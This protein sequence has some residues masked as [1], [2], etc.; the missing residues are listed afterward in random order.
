MGKI[1]RPR[2]GSLQIWPRKRAAKAL[3]RVN[4][5]AIKHAGMT[6][7]IA[8]KAGMATAIVRDKTDKSMT[9]NKKIALPVTILEVPNLKIYSVR[10]YK[11]GKVMKEFVVS[12][13]KEL[14]KVVKVAKQPVH[15]LPNVEG[16]D[17][18]RVIVY[19]ITKDLY[20][21]TPNLSEVALK[22]PNAI[23]FVKTHIGKEIN[24]SEILT[25][26]IV[27]VRGLTKGKGLS[28]PVKRFG[29]SL[30]SHKAEKG[31]RRPGSLAPWH[32]ARVTFRTAM[33]G[34]LGMF[35]RVHYNL[36]VVFKG[37]VGE[38]LPTTYGFKHYGTI[39]GNY[40]ILAGSVQGAAKR[41]ILITAPLRPTKKQLK[42]KYEFLELKL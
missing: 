28:G 24:A 35:S 20:K 11:H 29:I 16:F 40:I 3:P 14:K 17:E 38:H 36:P 1:S 21:K 32:P 13:D 26:S 41:E 27:D 2:F 39:G 37:K 30:K 31:Q 23:D 12:H 18:I 5:S 25:W 10:F 9:A 7:V 33:A 19:S 22:M 6:G 4:W 42:K 15:N 8:Y 34:Q